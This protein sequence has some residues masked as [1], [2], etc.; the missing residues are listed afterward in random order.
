VWIDAAG[1][2]AASPE[3]VGDA[4]P[5]LSFDVV[6]EAHF[7]FVWRTVRRLGVPGDAVDDVVQDVFLVV[8]RRLHLCCA[9]ESVRAWL[10]S[11]VRRVVRNARRSLYRKP[12]HLGGRAR[13]TC[14]VDAVASASAPSPHD[15]AIKAEALRTVHAILDAMP[16]ERREVF[17]LADLEQ[18]SVTDIAR[19]VGANVNTVHARLRAARADFDRGAARARVRDEWRT[20]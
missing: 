8:H 18:M 7:P 13:S 15:A 19:A 1:A 4:R 17:V 3:G 9:E 2:K 20:R 6:Y 16:D 14:D 10:F 5:V 12:A 11:V